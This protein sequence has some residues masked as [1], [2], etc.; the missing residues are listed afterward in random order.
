MAAQNWEV[1]CE[2]DECEQ[3]AYTTTKVFLVDDCPMDIH[4]C[5]HHAD[6]LAAT[7]LSGSLRLKSGDYLSEVY[8]IYGKG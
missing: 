4:V 6:D 3:R 1:F 8:R 5:R 2:L 7:R